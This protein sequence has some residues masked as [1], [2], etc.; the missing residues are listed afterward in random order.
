MDR[1]PDTLAHRDELAARGHGA[2]FGF[3]LCE[4][5]V[6]LR[7]DKQTQKLWC[8]SANLVSLIFPVCLP[9]LSLIGGGTP[10]FAG[11]LRFVLFQPQTVS[12]GFYLHSPKPPNLFRQLRPRYRD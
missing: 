5:V 11:Y 2:R 7:R 8:I 6:V 10:S 12:L 4:G 9:T 1:G 3:Y